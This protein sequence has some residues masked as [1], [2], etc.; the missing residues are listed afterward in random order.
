[1]IERRHLILTGSK[2]TADEL[3]KSASRFFAKVDVWFDRQTGKYM[4]DIVCRDSEWC[5]IKKALPV[6]RKEGSVYG[7]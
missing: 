5:R 7:A 2:A 6:I 4:A 1:M 3:E